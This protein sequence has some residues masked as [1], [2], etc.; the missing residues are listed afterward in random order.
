MPIV[1]KSEKTT[2]ETRITLDLSMAEAVAVRKACGFAAPRLPH[3][4]NTLRHVWTSM[5][6]GGV[7]E[8]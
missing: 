2:V 1:T 7:Q 8:S 3:V 4:E 6:E 5:F